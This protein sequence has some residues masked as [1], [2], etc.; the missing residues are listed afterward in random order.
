MILEPGEA[1]EAELSPRPPEL[2]EK[3][4]KLL[5]VLFLRG[6]WAFCLMYEEES[7]SVLNKDIFSQVVDSFVPVT[8]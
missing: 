4:G 7:V 1:K 6:S 2:G 5:W 8:F 3:Q